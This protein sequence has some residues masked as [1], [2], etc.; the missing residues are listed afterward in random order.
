VLALKNSLHI[1]CDEC[2]NN[3]EFV[4]VADQVIL[5]TRFIQNEDGSFIQEEDE[6]QILGEVKFYC[7]ECGADLSLHQKRFL[8][9][10]F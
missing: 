4:E 6:S 3:K 8:E 10:L 1:V 7:G 2:G 5:T 9:M